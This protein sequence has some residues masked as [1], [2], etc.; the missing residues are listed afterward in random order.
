[1]KTER[2]YILE[3]NETQARVMKDALEEYFR[4]RMN[5]WN[6]LAESLA[7]QNVDLSPEN[8][9]HKEIF[10]RFL[11]KRN[12][13]EIILSSVGK[14]LEW[15]YRQERT[16]EQMIAQ[17]IWQ[18]IRHELWR[19]QENRSEWS[20]DSREPMQVSKEPLPVIQTK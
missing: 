17:D 9:H 11:C 2:K 16:R 6:M 14:I 4:I 19:N 7:L 3:I 13:I 8:P 15:D 18:V 5:Q 1:M 20:V 12:D 10:E